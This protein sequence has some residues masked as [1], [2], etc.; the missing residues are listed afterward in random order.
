MKQPRYGGRQDEGLL[1]PDD[2]VSNM[3]V[4]HGLK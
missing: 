3:C 2:L 1:N 4:L